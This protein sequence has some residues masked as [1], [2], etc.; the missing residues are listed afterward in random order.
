MLLLIDDI[1]LN[2]E[3]EFT[4]YIDSVLEDVKINTF[5]DF[6]DFLIATDKNIELIVSDYDQIE[7][8][9]FAVKAM[10]LFEDASDAKSNIK[11]TK[12]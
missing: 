5:D 2:N 10:E 7:D 1:K 11:L 6:R 9:S 4:A 3:E 8:K 12:M